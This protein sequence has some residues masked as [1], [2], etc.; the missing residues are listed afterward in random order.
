MMIRGI[1]YIL[2]SRVLSKIQQ[3]EITQAQSS[4]ILALFYN[5]NSIVEYILL[6]AANLTNDHKS[7]LKIAA[8][9]FIRLHRIVDLS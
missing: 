9:L 7:S 6:Y 2:T 1:C 4:Q 8:S 3:S 5:T